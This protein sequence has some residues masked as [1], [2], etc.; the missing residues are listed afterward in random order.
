[1][2]DALDLGDNSACY[3]ARRNCSTSPK[4]LG[5]VLSLLA[6]VALLIAAGFALFGA[7]MVFPF[8]MLELIALGAAFVCYARHATDY[9]RIRI[10]AK[11]IE[12]EVCDGTRVRRHCFNQEWARLVIDRRRLALRSHGR[13]IEIGRFLGEVDHARLERELRR[14]LRPV[15]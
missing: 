4:L 2:L 1:M 13:E 14:W 9:E 5:G 7:W 15:A 8:A 12:V 3:V 6:F 10:D 11:R